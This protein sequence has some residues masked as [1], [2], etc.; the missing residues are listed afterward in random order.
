MVGENCIRLKRS[1]KGYD[2]G[3]RRA[4]RPLPTNSS[5]P[6]S[7][8]SSSML[9]QGPLQSH[10]AMDRCWNSTWH[11]GRY[12]ILPRLADLELP[13]GQHQNSP[14]TIFTVMPPF[15]RKFSAGGIPPFSA[16]TQNLPQ[17][18]E[19]PI[20]TV[21]NIDQRRPIPKFPGPLQH[22]HSQHI[23][24]SLIQKHLCEFVVR[25]TSCKIVEY[26]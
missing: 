21:T 2:Y 5:P 17:P 14:E 15:L 4:V 10:S 18:V 13:T 24:E 9:S 6:Y 3:L 16:V 20:L 12:E 11:M 23:C 1:Y 7:I 8:W 25:P 22:R 26:S 19:P